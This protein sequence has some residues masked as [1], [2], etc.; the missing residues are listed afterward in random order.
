M[1]QQELDDLIMAAAQPGNDAAVEQL[2]QAVKTAD[3]K[4]LKDSASN[5]DLLFDSWD[6]SV[7]KN[8]TKASVCLVLAE[9][10]ILDSSIFRI[11]LNSAIRKFL[12]PYLSS[13]A[14]AK[15]VGARDSSVGVCEVAARIRKLQH[16]KTNAYIYLF[17]SRT[18]G[19]IINI[20]KVVATIAVSTFSGGQISIPISSAVSTCYF[21]EAG[22]E[23][24]NLINT[25]KDALKPAAFYRE[26]LHHNSLGDLSETKTREIIQQMFVPSL[27]G[28]DQF[29]D[30]WNAAP[31]AVKTT[32][33]Q[34]T[35]R[36]ARSLLELQTQ[37]KDV[38][39][40]EKNLTEED[41][42]KLSRLFTHVR[43]GMTPKE[44]EMLA[45]CM[46]ELASCGDDTILHRLFD[47]VRGTVPFFPAEISAA[48]PLKNLEV[49]GR[50]P[51]R[52]FTGFLK[53]AE[54][55]YSRLEIAKLSMLLPLR[56]IMI[57]FEKLSVD[58]IS[59]ALFAAE[60]LRSDII[61]AIWKNKTRWNNKGSKNDYSEEILNF[62][63]M[64]N[65]CR[66]LSEEGLPKEWTAAQRELKRL[67]FDKADFQK[68]VLANAGE[69]IPS[70]ISPIQ[71]MRNM[72]PG[73]CQSLLVKLARHSA[74]LTEHIESG[75]GRKLLAAQNDGQPAKA[76]EAPMTSMKSYK[77][78]VAE[79]DNIVRVQIPENTKAIEVARAFG[80]LSENA[81]Y[82][83]AKERRR[84]LQ[85]RRAELETLVATV[86]PLDFHQ[87][88]ADTSKVSLGT[89]VTLQDASGTAKVYSIVGGWDGN[90]DRNLVAYKTKFAAALIGAKIGDT[91][92]LPDGSSVTVKSIDPL[93][94]DLIKE[95]SPEE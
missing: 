8:E 78:L 9:K 55:L 11:A 14:V 6:D 3:L 82:S 17:S 48:V 1:N 20:D 50:I 61:L 7:F 73:E 76:H 92:T 33:A 77:A 34:R 28:A 74:E 65:I 62:V 16:L 67:L 95:L 47:G 37:L 49:W 70:I 4:L 63:T 68:F 44:L 79:L 31:E 42:V 36:D 87:F 12:P 75:E 72:A 54:L 81:E 15:A 18:W 93:A 90:P 58:D 39:P 22:M 66:A 24:T 41:A 32:P 59:D 56:C 30:W 2:L 43:R 46:A 38:P 60:N 89:A 52:L 84:F 13:P 85:R 23:M 83:A 35:F 80:D 21:F 86:Q 29:T 71:R 40:T 26:K 69:N 94:A 57:I 64:A 51:V 45:D 19:R 91:V 27:M 88:K 25:R 5:F 10:S 53:V